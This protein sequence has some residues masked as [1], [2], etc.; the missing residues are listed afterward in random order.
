MSL[1]FNKFSVFFQVLFKIKNFWTY[2]KIYFFPDGK[3]H[4]LH[5]WNGTILLA[6]QNASNLG[7]INEVFFYRDY[8]KYFKNRNPQII[9]DIGANVGYFT[10]F[11]KTYFP[12]AKIYSFEPFSKSYE[13]LKEQIK[14]N[15]FS[16]VFT[17]KKA[18]AQKTGTAELNIV[19][20]CGENTLVKKSTAKEAIQIETISL[21]DIFN[22][23]KIASCDF[24]KVDCEGSEY[25]IFYNLPKHF[26]PKIKHLA[27]ETHNLD[28]Q[29]LNREALANFLKNQGL[30]II[31]E[32][33][34]ACPYLFASSK[35]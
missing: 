6:G 30:E 26:F 17:F 16:D 21:E 19:G 11:A 29:Q 25:E 5:F 12:A 27:M 7:I 2:F 20:D 31:V 23:E 22:K 10:I 33:L 9:I 24:L 3:N 15:N 35:S 8:L 14:L 32:N 34:G 28:Q 1:I 4:Q 18:V 13:Q